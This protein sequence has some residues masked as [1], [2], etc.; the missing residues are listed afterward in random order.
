MNK[1]PALGMAGTAMDAAEELR[2]YLDPDS[3]APWELTDEDHRALLPRL[4]RAI[5]A[6]AGSIDGI[7]QA[8]GDQYA[9]QQLT[10]SY[11]WAG[12]GRSSSPARR[13]VQ[14]R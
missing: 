8:A 1:H 2:G 14:L 9:R 13:A 10:D 3:P 12:A 4:E 7:A 11:H 6:I 5:S